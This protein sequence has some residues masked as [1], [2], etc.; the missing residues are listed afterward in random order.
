MKIILSGIT[1]FRNHGVEALVTTTIHELRARLPGCEFVVFDRA[2]EFDASRLSEKG[3]RF[4]YDH[5]ARP[6]YSSRLRQMLVSMS[7][8]VGRLDSNYQ[9]ALREI[10]SASAVIASGGDVFASEYGHRSL[11]SHLRPLEVAKKFK[12]PYFFHAQSIGPFKTDPD[13]RA[14]ARVAAGAAGITVRERLSHEYLVKHLAL[15][16]PRAVHTADPA[17]LLRLP[18]EDILSGMR[19]HYGI[20]QS[21][22]TVALSVSQ[23]ICNWT[24][25]D[26]ERHFA[27][28]CR[29]ITFLRSQLDA[30]IVL[31]PHVQ[32]V[33]VQ[34]DDRILATELMRH[35]RF[36]PQI[37]L[38]G[39]DFT[40][41]EFKGLISQCDLV[42]AER[43][44][45]AIAGLSTAVP[46]VAI[47]YSVKAEGILSDL[48]DLET[49]KNSLLIPLAEF[50]DEKTA[51]ETIK[52]A[53][54]DRD[55]IRRKLSSVL[56]GIRARASMSFDLIERALRSNSAA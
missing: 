8:Y 41:S 53:W 9:Q 49:V 43:M 4:M 48:F 27:S 16:S 15:Q 7:N 26:S 54:A 5:T 31:I 52:L 3:V 51:L 23:A 37:R 24:N 34:N 33:A 20:G 17:F 55:T 21:R 36:D 13:A 38:A 47:G 10:R 6:L 39:G 46:T 29:V 2:P 56:P 44:H 11:L 28:W 42:V 14:F 50:L 32:E 35:F 22:P 19:G 30:N 45:A 12:V 40:A 18:E 1:S 25:S